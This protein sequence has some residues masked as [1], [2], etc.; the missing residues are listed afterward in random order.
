M[1][2]DTVI[3]RRAKCV[4]PTRKYVYH[5]NTT[6][7]YTTSECVAMTSLYTEVKFRGTDSIKGRTQLQ[8]YLHLFGVKVVHNACVCTHTV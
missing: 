6:Y 7:S 2:A 3:H 5:N 8:E 1:L 4:T